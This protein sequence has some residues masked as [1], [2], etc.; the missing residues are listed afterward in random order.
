MVEKAF[1]F[2]KEIDREIQDQSEARHKGINPHRGSISVTFPRQT[3]PSSRIPPKEVDPTA[4]LKPIKKNRPH[5]IAVVP[6]KQ[7]DDVISQNTTATSE[8][9][10]GVEADTKTTSTSMSA[11]PTLESRKPSKKK[12]SKSRQQTVGAVSN[13]KTSGFV[14]YLDG[15][16]DFPQVMNKEDINYYNYNQ[17]LII[18]ICIQRGY[19]Y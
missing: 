1:A 6:T 9:E 2:W 12:D 8:Q 13:K 7:M 19:P 14:S 17:Q 11:P 18:N 16:I 5:S 4:F 15:P 3:P 10:N